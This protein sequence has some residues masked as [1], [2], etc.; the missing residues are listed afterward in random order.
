M[1]N[2]S[3]RRFLK[4]TLTGLVATL[5]STKP[6]LASTS[7]YQYKTPTTRDDLRYIPERDLLARMIFGEARNCPT[8]EQ[9][10]IGYTAINRA[11]DNKK[12]NGEKSLSDVLL[13][14]YRGNHQYDCFNNT[15]PKTATNFLRTLDPAKYDPKSWEK[16]KA[17]AYM[18]EKRQLPYLNQGQTIYVTKNRINY[19]QKTKTTPKWLKNAIEIEYFN[20]DNLKHKIYKDP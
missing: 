6:T 4:N 11:N 15:N 8:Y 19:W 16:S 1:Q 10:I 13:K 7:R 17:L 14:I 18:L 20:I 2:I 3:R 12:F 9:I 5:I